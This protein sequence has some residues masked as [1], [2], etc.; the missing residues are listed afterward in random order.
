[1]EHLS[2][3]HARG[4]RAVSL[5]KIHGNGFPSPCV[6]DEEFGIDAEEAVEEILIVERQA[7]DVAHGADS[8]GCETVGDAV[9]YAPEVGQRSVVPEFAAIA[10]LIEFGDAHA[11]FV[12]SH[13][14]G[15]YVH[16]DFAEIHV[17]ADAGSGGDA[18][19]G[20]HVADHTHGEVVRRETVGVEV[21]SDIHDH[22]VDGIDVD[23]LRG[24]IAQVDLVDASAVFDVESHP[25]RSHDIVDGQFRVGVEHLFRERFPAVTA[26]AVGVAHLTHHLE[27]AWAPPCAEG[28]EG[29]GDGEADSLVGA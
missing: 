13:L 9:A 16:R 15:L 20:E 19:F 14:L 4:F 11:V 6:V 1:M 29:R 28:L 21:G 22:L 2:A 7:C 26:E 23:I 10:H 27:E 24:D 18:S 5:H 17:G 12:G 8:V 3:A 25:W